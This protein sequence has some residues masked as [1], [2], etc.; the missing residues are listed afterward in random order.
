MD[1]NLEL[2]TLMWIGA[3]LLVIALGY[4]FW[5]KKW[6]WSR[7]ILKG[8]NID[9]QMISDEMRDA[10]RGKKSDDAQYL[11]LVGD[12]SIEEKVIG[13]VKYSP[14]PGRDFVTVFI[15]EDIFNMGIYDIYRP[16]A[17]AGFDSRN[18]KVKGIAPYTI[19]GRTTF[20]PSADSGCS[21]EEVYTKWNEYKLQKHLGYAIAQSFTQM[22]KGIFEAMAMKATSEADVVKDMQSWD[23]MKMAKDGMA[24]K[25]GGD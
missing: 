12:N 22:N 3:F 15:D 17:P 5:F 9:Q 16:M 4:H 25:K 1:V 11:I 18:I 24:M 2:T 13:K 19:K 6:K 21:W 20:I 23:Y 14:L 10:K 7:D 8:K